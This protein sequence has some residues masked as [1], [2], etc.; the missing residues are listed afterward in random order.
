M[1]K[2]LIANS[3]QE[4]ANKTKQINNMKTNHLQHHL[5]QNISRLSV[6]VTSGHFPH[7]Q[8]IDDPKGESDTVVTSKLTDHQMQAHIQ[9]LI[10]NL[11]ELSKTIN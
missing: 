1:L 3:Y 5:H 10:D 2:V 11:K 7:F 9:A 6:I 8:H 4:V